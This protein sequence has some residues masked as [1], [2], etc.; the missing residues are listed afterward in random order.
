MVE[1]SRTI[2]DRGGG[3]AVPQSKFQPFRAWVE[4]KFAIQC[5]GKNKENFVI[6]LRPKYRSGSS[7]TPPP[8]GP[9]RVNGWQNIRNY[10]L[11]I[12][13]IVNFIYRYNHHNSV[14]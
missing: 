1:K 14:I 7:R 6:Q 8:P 10:N 9:Q 5:V 2:K 11:L 4:K 3:L 12:L 13:T